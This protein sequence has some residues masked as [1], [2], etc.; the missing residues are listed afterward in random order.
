MD[1]EAQRARTREN[2]RRYRERLKAQGI[3]Q[4]PRTPEQRDQQREAA[5]QRRSL[6]KAAG[7]RTASATW[8][9]RNPDRHRANGTRWRT[10]NLE[11]AR[12]L[13]RSNQADRRSTPWGRINNRV[14]PIMHGAVRRASMRPSKYTAAIGYLW[15]ELY[16]HIEAQFLPGMTWGNWGEVWELDHITPL[17]S[18]KY[19]SL[20]DPLFREAWALTNLR[21]LWTEA[22]QAKGCKP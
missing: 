12:E 15:G 7:V 8:F 19:E 1:I 13:T 4:A 18:F 9:E 5:A 21:P 6:A 22:N 2:T 3:K 10:E 20:D 11:R 14:W 17:S 16:M